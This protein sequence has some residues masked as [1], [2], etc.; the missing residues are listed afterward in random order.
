[1][2]EQKVTTFGWYVLS[3]I[4]I[5]RSIVKAV[6][7]HLRLALG[8][9]FAAVALAV[10]PEGAERRAIIHALEPFEWQGDPERAA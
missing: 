8:F 4:G 7:Y 10:L 3:K 6:A 2:K 1:M 5:R 9:A